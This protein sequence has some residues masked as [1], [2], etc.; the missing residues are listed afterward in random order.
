MKKFIVFILAG[1]LTVSVFAQ[2]N[3]KE[4][5]VFV[6]VEDMPEYPGGDLALR[7]DI[8]ALVKYPEAAKDNGIQGKVYVSFIVKKDGSVANSRIARG[9]DPSLDKEALRVVNNLPKWKPGIQR[10]TAVNV[11]YTVPINFML[12]PQPLK[13]DLKPMSIKSVKN[14]S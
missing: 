14:N 10:G 13:D 1:L 7:D 4:K 2:E 9:V 5:G 6:I 3:N 11:S 8:A 12:D